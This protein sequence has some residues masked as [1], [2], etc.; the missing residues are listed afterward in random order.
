MLDKIENIAPGNDYQ[1]SSGNNAK[2]GYKRS[3]NSSYSSVNDSISLSPA[4]LYLSSVN[5]KL[6]HLQLD[7]DKLNIVFTFDNIEFSSSLAI[8][9]ILSVEKIDYIVKYPADPPA[10]TN[11]LTINLTSPIMKNSIDGSHIKS[12]LLY[13][14][15]F[16]ISAINAFGYNSGLLMESI[17]VQEL[18]AGLEKEIRSEFFYLNKCLIN[19]M[20]KYLS[21][22]IN[23]EKEMEATKSEIK[24]KNMQLNKT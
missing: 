16:C 18:F 15:K 21:L 11:Y 7:K 1:K 20:E 2:S 13:L 3:L 10:N 22:K 23:P 19:F 5:W 24:F 6:K 4:I 12:Q 8:G 14:T 9:E 17:Q